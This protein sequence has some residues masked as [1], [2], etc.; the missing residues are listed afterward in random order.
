M[1]K[2]DLAHVGIYVKDME[3]SKKFYMEVL[4]FEFEFETDPAKG[5][6]LCFLKNGTCKIELIEKPEFVK[7]DGHIDHLCIKVDDIKEA[8]ENLKKHNV[9]ISGEIMTMPQVFNGIKNIF[10]RGPDG[11]RLEFNEFL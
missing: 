3:V 2:Y 5:V 6:H 10:F 11:E 7:E 8:V 9:E 1:T 4:G